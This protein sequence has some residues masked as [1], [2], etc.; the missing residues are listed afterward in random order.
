MGAV[1]QCEKARRAHGPTLDLYRGFVPLALLLYWIWMETR[2]SRFAVSRDRKLIEVGWSQ[3]PLARAWQL[4]CDPF[5]TI[6]ALWLAC[7]EALHDAAHWRAE[8]TDD[9]EKAKIGAWLK[10]PDRSLWWVIQMDYSIGTHALEHVLSGAVARADANGRGPSDLGLMVEAIEWVE[11][12]DLTLPLH[13][14][15]WGRQTPQQIHDRSL[16]H[17][18]WLRGAAKVGPIDDAPAGEAPPLVRPP[19]VPGFPTDLITEA[20]VCARSSTPEERL[21]AWESVGAYAA[22]RRRRENTKRVPL[23]LRIAAYLARNE[24]REPV[25]RPG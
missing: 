4:G 8:G 17:R 5:N 15:H 23:G 25:L 10:R 20:K 11:T 12:T 14:R 13:A 16:K 3:T 24:V 9:E 2:W 18:D 6:G 22:A 1:A 19:G 7:I 21:R